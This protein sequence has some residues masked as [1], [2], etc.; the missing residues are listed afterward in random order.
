MKGGTERFARDFSAH[1]V[2][3]G[4]N[5]IGVV[6][7]PPEQTA[8]WEACG[9]EGGKQFFRIAARSM[10]LEDF[11]SFKN[12]EEVAQE[13]QFEIASIRATIRATHPDIVFLNGFSQ[14]SWLL[15]RAAAE[16]GIPTVFQHAGIEVLAM[17]YYTDLY[18]EGSL[19]IKALLERNATETATANIFLNEHSRKAC[20]ESVH[21]NTMSGVSILPLPH[22]G[23]GY[24]ESV[25]RVSETRS[26]GVVARWE[27]GKNHAA[28]VALA[29]E[30]QE[31]SLPW[32]ITAVTAIPSTQ[33]NLEFK[34]EY[35][36]LIK[37]LAPMDHEALRAFYKEQDICLLP[38]LFE[39]AGG[40]VAEALAKGTPTLISEGVGW[41]DEY[42]ETGMDSWIVD[43]SDPKKVVETLKKQFAR[44]QWPETAKL[45][46]YIQEHHDPKKVF[47]QYLSVFES[48]TK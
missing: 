5:W 41:V 2:E 9:E 21:P 44:T 4:H 39:T 33:K 26:I 24:R 1:V 22:A 14:Y 30:I 35:R 38:S 42:R 6:Q 29:K 18:S 7:G 37:V 11:A 12:V 40:V 31:Q 13:F 32:T 48:L 17:S 15:L 27:R 20:I 23:W 8:A 19:Y 43:F 36:S 25:P 47:T 46:A 16:E 45:A 3:Q 10:P 34:E 28:L